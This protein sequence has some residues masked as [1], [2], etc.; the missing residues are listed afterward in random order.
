MQADAHHP[1]AFLGQLVEGV[2]QIAEELL[3]LG[4]AVERHDLHV[5]GV[6]L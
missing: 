1:P 5:V 6:K 3:A 2:A 4:K